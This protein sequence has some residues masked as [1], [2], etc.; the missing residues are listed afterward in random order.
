MAPPPLPAHLGPYASYLFEHEV[1]GEVLAKGVAAAY[2]AQPDDAVGYLAA[3]LLRHADDERR[4][5]A[6]QREHDER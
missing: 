6:L 1:F 3:W 4:L 5:A 2:L